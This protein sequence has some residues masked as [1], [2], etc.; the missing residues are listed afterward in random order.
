MS[1]LCIDFG[2]SCIKSSYSDK[3]RVE[4]LL[5]NGNRLINNCITFK[6][7]RQYGSVAFNNYNNSE[8]TVVNLKRIICLNKDKLEQT[9]YLQNEKIDKNSGLFRIKLNDKEYKICVQH[10]IGMILKYISNIRNNR[11][12]SISVPDSFNDIQRQILIDSSRAFDLEVFSLVNESQAISLDYGFYKCFKEKFDQESKVLFISLNETSLSLFITCF[13]NNQIEVISNSTSYDLGGCKINEILISFMI[14]EINEYFSTNIERNKKALLKIIKECEKAKKILS[15]NT[16]YLFFIEC[17]YEGEDYS[18]MISRKNFESMITIYI[19]NINKFIQTYLTEQ[20]EIKNNSWNNVE[21]LGGNTRIPI[22]KENIE[23]LLNVELNSTLNFDETISKGM[24]LYNSIQNGSNSLKEFKLK[25]RNDVLNE[26]VVNDK[27]KLK[28]FDIGTYLPKTCKITLPYSLD[29]QIKIFGNGQI[30]N[31][32]FFSTQE[33]GNYD[34]IVI[35]LRKDSNYITRITKIK[36]SRLVECKNTEQNSNDNKSVGDNQENIDEDN[37]NG[38]NIQHDNAQQEH[39]EQANIQQDHTENNNIDQDNTEKDNIQQDHIQQD[40]TEQDHAEQDNTEQDHI[41]QDHIEQYSNQQDDTE[42]DHAE[43]DD[44]EQDHTEQ[45]NI[46]N[47]DT[48]QNNIQHDDTEQDHT[49]NNNTEQDI[50]EKK[51]KTEIIEINPLISDTNCISEKDI[52]EIRIIE[53]TMNNNDNIV[54]DFNEY[55]NKF[56]SFYFSNTDH[57][58]KVTNKDDIELLKKV[59]LILSYEIVIS[60]L[61]EFKKI[62]YLF[63]D[64]INKITK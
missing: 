9:P 38:D 17:L 42:Q 13:S 39:T 4:M 43:H 61:E 14:S 11:K 22:L 35:F 50:L 44:T 21:L 25:L 37:Q 18:R 27:E 49:E 64:I 32:Y 3:G 5:E 31:K 16:E 10:V 28:I 20:S 54:K 58:K 15:A 19:E 33:Y 24:V 36:I 1:I 12:I 7:N 40:D 34:K 48:E 46:Q 52:E 55:R 56:E 51:F 47:D 53:K 41:E 23:K 60:D 8:N 59:D 29:F 62:F 30:L 26:I 45:D 57:F 63:K 2:N 6:E